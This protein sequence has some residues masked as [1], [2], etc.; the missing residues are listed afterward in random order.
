MN[1]EDYVIHNRGI[2]GVK[3]RPVFDWFGKP[4]NGMYFVKSTLAIGPYIPLQLNLV[5]LAIERTV[6]RSDPDIGSKLFQYTGHRYLIDNA[7]R[8]RDW[9]RKSGLLE[10]LPDARRKKDRGNR[11]PFPVELAYFRFD[12]VNARTRRRLRNIFDAPEP[13]PKIRGLHRSLRKSPDADAMIASFY[14]RVQVRGESPEISVPLGTAVA[15][16]PI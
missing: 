13:G 3:S 1:T 11:F 15:V 8:L 12:I 14:R 10:K 5:G 2:E 9:Y 4:M 7:Y 6:L 16:D